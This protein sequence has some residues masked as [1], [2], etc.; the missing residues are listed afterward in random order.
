MYA[1]PLTHSCYIRM[2][3]RRIIFEIKSPKESRPPGLELGKKPYR[4]IFM[5]HQFIIFLSRGSQDT[6]NNEQIQNAVENYIDPFV[7]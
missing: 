2:I 6:S 5:P 4:K 1:L 3:R 7:K